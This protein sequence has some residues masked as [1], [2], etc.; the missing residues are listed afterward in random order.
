M[1][2]NFYQ[3]TDDILKSLDDMRPSNTKNSDNSR[4]LECLA[5]DIMTLKENIERQHT[6]LIAS[7]TILEETM[8]LIEIATQATETFKG[9]RTNAECVWASYW[10][11]LKECEEAVIEMKYICS[12]KTRGQGWVDGSC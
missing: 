12:G 3:L 1:D 10:G 8:H 11:I 7:T 6:R 5:A 4:A 2:R 9:K